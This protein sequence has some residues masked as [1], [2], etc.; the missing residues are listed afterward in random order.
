MIYFVLAASCFI[1]GT[2]LRVGYLIIHRPRKPLPPIV[3]GL[4]ASGAMWRAK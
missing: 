2:C 4:L 3:A 1:T